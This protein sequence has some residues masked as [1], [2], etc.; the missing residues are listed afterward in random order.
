MAGIFQCS[1]NVQEDWYDG[2]VSNAWRT[3][4]VGFAR[5]IAAADRMESDLAGLG[6]ANG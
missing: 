1:T 2:Y 3:T 4:L 6:A 5:G